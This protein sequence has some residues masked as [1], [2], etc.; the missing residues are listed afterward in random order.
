M[1]EFSGMLRLLVLAPAAPVVA[2]LP[3]GPAGLRRGHEVEYRD[4]PANG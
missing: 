2:V 4:V 1:E 3:R